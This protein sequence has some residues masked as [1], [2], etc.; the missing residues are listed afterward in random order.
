MASQ[1]VVQPPGEGYT[2]SPSHPRS[3]DADSLRPKWTGRVGHK[4]VNS[5]VAPSEPA[6][7]LDAS[8]ARPAG[9]SAV[10][11]VIEPVLTTGVSDGTRVIIIT[12]FITAN[13]VQFIS[14]F[15]T[16]SGGI[17]LTHALGRETGPGKA[18]WMA[19][20]YSITQ[21]TFVLVSGR[22]GAIYGHHRLSLIGLGMFGIFSIVNGFCRSF[23]SF[24]AV[25][26]LSGIG[27]GIYMP[28]AITA[29]GLMVPPG[30]TRTLLYGIFAAAP[31]LGGL[32]GAL[33]AGLC[34]EWEGMWSW[35][36]L[37]GALG[38]ISVA[39][40]IFLAV[41]LP[42]ERP[43]D[44][45]GKLDTFGACLGLSGLLLFNIAWSQAPAIGWSMPSEIAILTVSVVV[46]VGF[47]FWEHR[48][49]SA[50]I[51]PLHIFRAP[52]FLAMIFVVLFSYMSFGIALW[53]SISWQQTLRQ[54]S[55]LQ[56]AVNLIPFGLGSTAAVGLAAYLLPRVE[57]KLVM[58]V[59]VVA[60]IGASLLLATMPMQQTYWAQV[61]PA[62][63][64]CGCCPDFVY[65]AA[66]VIASN[67]VTRKHQGIASSLVGTLNL[68]GIS[69]GL[70]FA[71]TIEVE[72][73]KKSKSPLLGAAA[74]MESIMSG[75]KAALYF[76]AALAAVGL[77]LDFAF[78][79]VPKVDRQGWGDEDGEDP[80]L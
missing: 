26:A 69:L 20:S 53:Y 18:N 12:L 7:L 13:L 16:L 70:G 4:G 77:L 21:S 30:P 75:F 48:V 61:F 9:P 22:L 79:R 78:V 66:Q 80:S 15:I 60:V 63:L 28:N 54:L 72:V 11:D 6:V 46:F 58:A 38:V 74:T 41:I 29:L 23:A 37:F 35:T 71:G 40:C 3:R 67:S 57:A 52:T 59:G 55:V 25:R 44:P 5:P 62:M 68:Y 43:V 27:G 34:A 76:S 14:N 65:L 45:K 56:I 50:P 36:V 24:V 31:P 39:S 10:F 51:M 64:L 1:T 8:E 19:A 49:A 2:T 73:A 33:F 47:L 32:V 42:E 17:T